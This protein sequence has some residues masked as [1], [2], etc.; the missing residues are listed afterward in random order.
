MR[1]VDTLRG[2]LPVLDTWR[3][4]R[5]TDTGWTAVNEKGERLNI[6]Y[7]P[8]ERDSGLARVPP[9]DMDYVTLVRGGV[10]EG[11]ALIERAPRAKSKK[12]APAF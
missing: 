7:P 2:P 1:T 11:V 3:E 10:I 4:C 6:T 5:N 12:K 8:S 9:D